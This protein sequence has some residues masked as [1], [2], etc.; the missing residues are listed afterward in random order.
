MNVNTAYLQRKALK[1]DV[2]VH[3]P[4]DEMMRL[5]YGIS[6]C[7]LMGEPILAVFGIIT[8]HPALIANFGFIISGYSSPLLYIRRDKKMLVLTVH[9]AGY[10]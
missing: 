5:D 1:Q 7:L 8:S 6:S 9:D 2:Y 10:L 4:K 3:P